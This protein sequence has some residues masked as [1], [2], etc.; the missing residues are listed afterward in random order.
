MVHHIESPTTVPVSR[1][2]SEL[3]AGRLHR[4]ETLSP[5]RPAGMWLTGGGGR[6]AVEASPMTT[7]TR[8]PTRGDLT[9]EI[10]QLFAQ[11]AALLDQWRLQDWLRV[12]SDDCHCYLRTTVTANVRGSV[13]RLFLVADDY[14]HTVE[15]VASLERRFDTEQE[16]PPRIRRTL[17]NIAV[18][19][20]RSG[21][22]A[23]DA[24]FT[25][26]RTRDGIIDRFLGRY[27]YVIVCDAA[28]DLRIGHR[29]VLL[30]HGAVG[31]CGPVD[32]IL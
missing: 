14:R 13:T 20:L 2:P 21:H 28:G 25:V 5:T 3:G 26:C 6:C 12:L 18:S 32:F 4:R 15:R 19:Y 23:A 16:A 24:A 9:N 1:P 31:P 7:A 8:S 29:H 10:L 27:Q 11:E 17:A 30:D 22:Y